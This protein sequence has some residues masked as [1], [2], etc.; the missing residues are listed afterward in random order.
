MTGHIK[1]FTTWCAG[2]DWFTSLTE[3]QQALMQNVF[4]QTN[5]LL[6][7]ILLSKNPADLI[8]T[9]GKRKLTEI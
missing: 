1:N 3:D 4:S 7:K 5:L 2:T 8:Q 6:V 9:W